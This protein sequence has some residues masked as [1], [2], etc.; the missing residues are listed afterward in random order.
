MFSVT[1][2]CE[3]RN[4]DMGQGVKELPSYKY[5]ALDDFWMVKFSY[6]FGKGLWVGWRE[7]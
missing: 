6:I 3:H 7:V 4:H 1:E 5:D 2:G